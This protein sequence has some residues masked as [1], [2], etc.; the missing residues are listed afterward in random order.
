MM[1]GVVDAAVSGVVAPLEGDDGGMQQ[2][3]AAFVVPEEGTA[4]TIA[5]V[6]EHCRATISQPYK[7]PRHIILCDKLP[8]NK[9]G[10]IVKRLVVSSF[11]EPAVAAKG[12]GVGRDLFSYKA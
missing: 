4:L 10:K 11:W 9:N 8:R 1:P 2:V 6:H 12:F 5:D 7:R 3:V